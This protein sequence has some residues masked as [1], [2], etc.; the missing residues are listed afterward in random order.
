MKTYLIGVGGVGGYF[1]GMLQNAGFDVTFVS[2]GD[3]FR[4]MQQNGLILHTVEGKVELP[5]VDV[6]DDISKI[7][8]PDLILLFV[9]T[10]ATEGVIQ[11]LQSVVTNNTVILTFQTGFE[12]DRIIREHLPE[13]VVHP[14]L[15]YINARKAGPGQI[16]QVSG[17]CRLVYGPREGSADEAILRIQE[18]FSQTGLDIRLSSDIE[19]EIWKKLVWI[20]CFSGV[21][22]L[23]RSEIGRI[24]NHPLGE[25]V[26]RRALDEAFAIADACHVNLSEADL[27]EILSKIP[28]HQTV[29][30]LAKTSLLLDL[31]KGNQTE[32]DTMHGALLA[33][34][35]LHGLKTPIL[36]TITAVIKVHDD[37][38]STE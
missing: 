18:R 26:L 4:A 30:P 36:D 29:A 16:E 9:K 11:K 27:Q 25:N 20:C 24:L 17:L 31:E 15:A 13:N 1:G 10:T 19:R 6:L 7:S 3:H 22:V 2:R 35:R 38:L 5:Q 34:A 37:S 33:K 28:Y 12:N 14:G 8:Q 23:F 21:T 32:V